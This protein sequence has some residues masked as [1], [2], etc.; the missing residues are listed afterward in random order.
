M[1]V[2]SLLVQYT[3]QDAIRYV[4]HLVVFPLR[5]IK[6][7]SEYIHIL[8]PPDDWIR[9]DWIKQCGNIYV[10]WLNVKLYSYIKVTSQSL[11]GA[12]L[13][14]GFRFPLE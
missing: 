5:C 2:F 12:F 4:Q 3:Q 1:L 9:C 8:F 6:E 10:V 13:W 14:S 11:Y 7:S